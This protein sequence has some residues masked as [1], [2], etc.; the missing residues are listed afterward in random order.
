[1]ANRNRDRKL[2]SVYNWWVSFSMG[3]CIRLCLGKNRLK[4]SNID[5]LIMGHDYY[6][7]K[8]FIVQEE[9][10]LEVLKNLSKKN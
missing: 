7:T 8:D 9:L 5:E 10:K 6:K 3:R 2:R 1:M 4:M